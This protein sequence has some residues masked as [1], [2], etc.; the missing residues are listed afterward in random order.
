M[1]PIYVLIGTIVLTALADRFNK[2]AKWITVA[3]IIGALCTLTIP[4]T[5][6]LLVFDTFTIF[7]TVLFL[8]VA[9][10]VALFGTEGVAYYPSLL[11]TTMG[12]IVAT[13]SKD[14][15]M[16]FI[17]IELVTTPSYVLVAYHKTR[18]R[19]EAATKYFVVSIVA[20]A[21]LI[22]GLALLAITSGSTTISE[23]QPSTDPVFLLGLVAF[24][25][26]LGFKLGIFPFNFWIPDVYQGAPPAVAGLL[27]GA[28]KKAGFA[29][30]LR[31]A[32]VVAVGLKSWTLL[33][34]VIA[35]FSMTIPN[36][37]AI[38]QTNLRRMLSYS[39]M[40]HAGFLL[41][42]VALM[43]PLGVSGTLFH[44]FTHAFMAAGAF[45]VLGVLQ[46]YKMETLKDIRGLAKRSTFL[47]LS[48][49]LFLLSLTGIPLLAGFASK[50]YLFYVTMEGGLLWL[51]IAAIANSVLSLYYYFLI[52]RAM[53]GHEPKGNH[54]APPR[55]MFLAI[56]LCLLVTIA[57]GVYP[58]PMIDFAV[59]AAQVLF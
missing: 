22:L 52:I 57:F 26:G 44:A 16:L 38:L 29:A 9:L 30:F 5:S 7:F 12:M 21:L 43:T 39:I 37:I 47:S 32:A 18:E 55:S 53:Y 35:V 17:G 3:G 23:L 27:A 19:M 36:I 41:M 49:M 2:N 28:S 42:G 25:A 10:A 56:L 8:A 33:L 58:Q 40:T 4:Y 46:Q 15:M 51:G 45:L 24:I 59:A 48:L 31:I 34:A 54:I 1:I 11:L 13:A 6:E 14:V 50:F 20:S